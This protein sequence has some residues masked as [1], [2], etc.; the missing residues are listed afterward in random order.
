MSLRGSEA[1]VT[2][3]IQSYHLLA[4]LFFV[5]ASAAVSVRLLLLARRTRQKPE[6]FLGLGLLGT[7]VL[8]Y[9]VL[10]A[11][12]ILRGAEQTHTVAPLDRTLQ[13]CGQVLHDAG[14]TMIVIFVVSTFRPHERWANALAVLLIGALWG[15]TLG[16]ELTNGFYFVGRGNGFWWLEYAAIWSYPLWTM[17]ESY[18]Y[19]ALMRRRQ[20]LGLADPMVTNRFLLWGSASLGTAL[21]TWTSSIGFFL[22]QRPDVV[23]AWEPVIQTFTATFGVATVALFY[24]TFFPPSWYRER[25]VAARSATAG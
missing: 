24:L 8:G 10:I 14:V 15:G 21:A 5:L 12:A 20:A 22:P 11:A 4:T 6:L 9:G 19:F 17:V 23:A 2:Q 13:A 16:W 25:I 3:L 18:R 7:A 1:R